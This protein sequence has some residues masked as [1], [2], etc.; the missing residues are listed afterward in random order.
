MSQAADLARVTDGATEGA[1]QQHYDLSND[2]FALWLDPEMVYSCALFGPGA[3]TLEAAQVE[4][5]D[6]HAKAAGARA[7]SRILDIGCGWGA[8][9]RRLLDHY[10]V[11]HV[12]GLTLSQAQLDW[13]AEN[14]PQRFDTQL[15]PWQEARFDTPF[16]GIISIGAFEHFARLGLEPDRKLSAYQ[17]FF[18]QC[19]NWLEPAGRLSLQT[20]VYDAADEAE[21]SRFF[22]ESIFPESNLPHVDEVFRASRRTFSPVQVRVDG[23]DYA[24][25]LRHWLS[26]LKNAKDAAIALVGPEHYGDFVRYLGMMVIAFDRRKMNLL[27]VEF[28][29][30][31]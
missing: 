22:A 25:T 15:R 13:I 20:I 27:R 5:L 29:R 18:E 9:A 14:P 19:A 16:S 7:G 21:F 17:R 28:V 4:K 23:T 1:I 8:M 12:D 30:N 11:E 24:Q 31:P 10:E 2:F 26:R 6:W 3:T